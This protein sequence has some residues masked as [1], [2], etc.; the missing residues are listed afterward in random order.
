M[1]SVRAVIPDLL[2]ATT[3]RLKY[4]EISESAKLKG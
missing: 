4:P 1:K 3:K 2:N